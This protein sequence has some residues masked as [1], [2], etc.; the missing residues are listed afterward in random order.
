MFCAVK[1][2]HEKPSFD[3]LE[4]FGKCEIALKLCADCKQEFDN[5]PDGMALL[6]IIKD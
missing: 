2:C 1:N 5:N 3:Y 6:S 4:K